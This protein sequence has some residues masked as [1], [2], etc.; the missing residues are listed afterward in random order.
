M[1]A[2]IKNIIFSEFQAKIAELDISITSEI[3]IEP[4]MKKYENQGHKCK[5]LS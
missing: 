1:R 3:I 5:T 2:S 4:E